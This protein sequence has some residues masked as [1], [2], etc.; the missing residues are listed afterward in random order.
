[1]ASTLAHHLRELEAFL[2]RHGDAPEWTGILIVEDGEI[3]Y[4]PRTRIPRSSLQTPNNFASRFDELVARGYGWINLVGN[5]VVE[6]KLIV[7]L[8]TPRQSSDLP[9]SQVPV[10]VSGPPCD[11]SGKQRW[12]LWDR[13]DLV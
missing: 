3:T 8:E 5:G 12:K 4:G 10:I 9:A 6:G 13:V 1:M 11:S 7:S 2:R